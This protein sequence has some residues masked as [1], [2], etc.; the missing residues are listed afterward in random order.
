VDELPPFFLEE[1]PW[2]GPGEEFLH[3]GHQ[4]I[5]LEGR[6]TWAS[7]CGGPSAARG[8]PAWGG[9]VGWYAGDLDG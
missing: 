1:A 5:R 8:T 3:W 2:W 7:L 6:Q 4:K 9:G